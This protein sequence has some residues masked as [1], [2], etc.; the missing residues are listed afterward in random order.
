MPTGKRT[1]RQR[2]V[3]LR[4]IPYGEDYQVLKDG[5]HT[6]C[7]NGAHLFVLRPPRDRLKDKRDLEDFAIGADEFYRRLVHHFDRRGRWKPLRLFRHPR[8]RDY[9]HVGY[10]A[11]P[12]SRMRWLERQ[13]EA[14]DPDAVA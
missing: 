2:K 3:T 8:Y 7:R 12:E 14:P 1:V 13:G 5:A 9:I 11:D 4:P 6:P 10:D